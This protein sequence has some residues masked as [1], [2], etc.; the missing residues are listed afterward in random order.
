[1]RFPKSWSVAQ[2]R[3]WAKLEAEVRKC[4]VAQLARIRE[5]E[6]IERDHVFNENDRA[7]LTRELAEQTKLSDKWCQEAQRV[8]ADN[9]R[10]QQLLDNCEL[11]LKK[12]V[13]TFENPAPIP[14]LLHCPLC[15]ARHIDAGAFATKV[16]HTHACQSCGHVWRPSVVPTFGV[17]F[18]PGFKS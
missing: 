9:A 12:A 14:M 5:L 6:S 11:A 10:K 18:L 3:R 16:H 15:N 4:E 17:Q 8:A 1:M 13:A 7:N 2:R